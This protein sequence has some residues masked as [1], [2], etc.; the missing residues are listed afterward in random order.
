M[1]AIRSRYRLVGIALIALAMASANRGLTAAEPGVPTVDDILK[2]NFERVAGPETGGAVVYPD[3]TSNWFDHSIGSPTV[4]FDGTTWRMWFVGMSRTQD[5]AIPYGFAEK[6]GLATSHDG[7]HW[8]IANGGRPVLDNGTQGTFDDSGLAHP[9]VLRVGQRFMLWYGGIDGRSGKDVGVGPPHVRVEQIG[10]A[11]STDGVH[12]KR[13]NNGAPVLKIGAPDSIDAVQAT[14]C[15]IIRRGDE[16][17]MWYGAYNGK[18][19]IGLAT[20][21]D[22]IHWKKQNDGRSLPGL[23]GPKQLGPSVHF[24]GNKYLMFYNTIRATDNGGTQW[25]LY[26]ATSVDGIRWKPARNNK[27][28]VGP[29]PPGNFGSA[30]GKRGNNHAVHPTK[31][32]VHGNRVRYWYGAEGNKPRPG[33]KYAASAVGLMQADIKP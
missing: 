12:W 15:H 28:L 21:K 3:H 13:E 20:S 9:F 31:L 17:V 2:L 4:D 30:D 23:Y 16:F 5:P 27:P 18:H 22:G 25:T 7:V 33:R 24:D 14:G 11:T 19:T 29:A 6:I 1:Q 10:L 32:I 8:E 26:S